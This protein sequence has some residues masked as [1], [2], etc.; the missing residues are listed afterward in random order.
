MN[1]VFVLENKH[2]LFYLVPS[3]CIIYLFANVIVS[4]RKELVIPIFVGLIGF[5]VT[6]LLAGHL[7]IKFRKIMCTCDNT[8]KWNGSYDRPEYA[9]TSCKSRYDEW[10]NRY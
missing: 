10:R 3:A 1:S 8:C 6:G 7:A 2:K 5:V 9:C 4:S